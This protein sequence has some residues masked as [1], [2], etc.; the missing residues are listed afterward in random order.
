MPLNKDGGCFSS[1]RFDALFLFLWTE[2]TILGRGFR[3][4]K[5]FVGRRGQGGKFIVIW[6]VCPDFSDSDYFF[7]FL[8]GTLGAETEDG[9]RWGAICIGGSG[10][11]D[12]F[13]CSLSTFSFQ[14]RIPMSPQN[15]VYDIFIDRFPCQRI[16]GQKG[17]FTEG[18][19]DPRNPLGIPA[20]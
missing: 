15:F 7:N 20:D 4:R 17:A 9:A 16:P 6:T 1:Y 18:V 8:I 10:C 12:F 5:I 11:L 13:S 3:G 2:R 14:G 19:D